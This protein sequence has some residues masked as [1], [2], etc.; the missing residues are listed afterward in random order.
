[1]KIL[2]EVVECICQWK[3]LLKRTKTIEKTFKLIN[4]VNGNCTGKMEN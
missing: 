1:M 2:V 4:E 3:H